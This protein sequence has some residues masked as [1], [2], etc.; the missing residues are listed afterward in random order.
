MN[1]PSSREARIIAPD[2]AMDLI[3]G[4]GASQTIDR[5][6]S[7]G[8]AI[9]SIAM[10]EF[11]AGLLDAAEVKVGTLALILQVTAAGFCLATL[12]LVGRL[13]EIFVL[14]HFAVDAFRLH[15][16]LENPEGLF[17]LAVAY[18]YLHLDTQNC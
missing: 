13:L 2:M 8:R 9:K 12:A 1:V 3:A 4:A 6:L 17:D 7:D 5:H 14:A 15:F 10:M 11:S 16:T 18:C